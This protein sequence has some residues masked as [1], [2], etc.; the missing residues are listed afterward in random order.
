[1]A[2]VDPPLLD[3]ALRLRVIEGDCGGLRGPDAKVPG[4]CSTASRE[5]DDGE[6]AARE[7]AAWRGEVGE[8]SAAFDMFRG[9]PVGGLVSLFCVHAATQA[10]RALPSAPSAPKPGAM[11]PAAFTPVAFSVVF[12]RALRSGESAELRGHVRHSGRRVVTATGAVWQR[13]R[14]CAEAVVTFALLSS[15]ADIALPDGPTITP[16]LGSSSA[17]AA[18]ALQ[19]RHPTLLLADPMPE[20]PPPAALPRVWATNT[21]RAAAATGVD[22]LPLDVRFT[23]DSAARKFLQH[24]RIDADAGDAPRDRRDSLRQRG[25]LRFADGRPVDVTALPYVVDSL[26]PPVLGL[27]ELRRSWV[28]TLT[29]HAQVRAVPRSLPEAQAAADLRVESGDAAALHRGGWVAFE[30]EARLVAGG[31]AGVDGRVWDAFGV[32]LVESRQLAAIRA[33]PTRARSAKL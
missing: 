10:V 32:L 26:V 27:A 2:A 20:L 11:E 1:M 24:R 19:Q 29:L 15:A 7:G 18:T 8:V 17:D 28:P 25:W 16:Q 5:C 9:V 3:A 33:P 12:T 4:G 23:L 13:G 30:F 22:G 14:C 21:P 31:L 6:R